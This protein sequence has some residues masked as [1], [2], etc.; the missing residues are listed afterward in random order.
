MQNKYIYIIYINYV[1]RFHPDQSYGCYNLPNRQ[2]V[3]R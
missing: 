2:T 3:V 1:F